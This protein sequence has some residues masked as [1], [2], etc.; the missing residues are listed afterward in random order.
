[1]THDPFEMIDPKPNDII[2]YPSG[3][4]FFYSARGERTL[5]NSVVESEG[6]E[7]WAEL[8]E[9]GQPDD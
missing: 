1:M 7:A 2:L 5:T 6:T 8:I 3:K 4:W 9:E